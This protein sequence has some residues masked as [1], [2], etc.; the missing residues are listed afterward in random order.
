MNALA[1]L[2]SPQARAELF[3]P[4][5]GV[6]PG[7]LH[8]RGLAR[9][10]GLGLSTVGQELRARCPYRTPQSCN[11]ESCNLSEMSCAR[12]KANPETSP[13]IFNPPFSLLFGGGSVAL[14]PC[15]LASW[16]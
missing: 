16:R 1:R 3:R 5:F 14:R 2:L 9:Q 15:F 4:L 13:S 7:R 11:Q 6:D 10:S 8:L 12:A